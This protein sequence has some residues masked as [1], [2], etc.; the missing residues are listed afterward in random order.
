MLALDQHVRSIHLGHDVGRKVIKY[1][2]VLYRF[3]RTSRDVELWRP[4]LDIVRVGH[5][6]MCDIRPSPNLVWTRTLASGQTTFKIRITHDAE[7]GVATP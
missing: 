2:S 4:A 5:G 6:I 3:A 1:V 7:S